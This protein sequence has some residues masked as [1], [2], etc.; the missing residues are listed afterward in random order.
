MPNMTA[1]T[2]TATITITGG[3]E[4]VTVVVEQ[5]G[6]AVSLSVTPENVFFEAAGGTETA[7]VSSNVS[8]TASDNATWLTLNPS[9]G[10]GNGN[11]TITCQ[12]YTGTQPRTAT[13]TVTG[14]GITRTITVEQAGIQPFLSANPTTVFF[15]ATGGMNEVIVNSNLNWTVSEG[16]TWLTLSP[17]TGNGIGSFVINCAPNPGTQIRNALITLSGGGLERIIEVGQA[18]AVPY[19]TVNQDFIYFNPPGGSGE[20]ELSSNIG[21]IVTSSETWASITPVSGNGNASLYVDCLVNNNPDPR[22]AVFT[23]IGGGINTSFTLEQLGTSIFCQDSETT[24]DTMLCAGQSITIGNNTYT[25]TGSYENLFQT[26]DGC[27]SL[28]TLDLEVFDIAQLLPSELTTCPGQPA[29]ILVPAGYEIGLMGV[30]SGNTLSLNVGTYEVTIADDLFACTATQTVTVVEEGLGVA[31]TGQATICANEPHPLQATPAATYLWS[32]NETTATINVSAPGTY[33]VTATDA[34]GCE[35]NSCFEVTEDLTFPSFSDCPEDQLVT[36]D[37]GETAAAIDWIPPFATDNCGNDP[38]V[39]QSSHEPGSI[40]NVGT[41]AVSYTVTDANGNAT[42]CTFSVTVQTTPTEDLTFYIDTTGFTRSGDT[43]CVPVRVLN[44]TEVAAFQFSLAAPDEMQSSL[45][46]IDAVAPLTNID[47]VGGLFYQEETPNLGQL[48]W[49]NPTGDGLTLADST[50]I[51]QIKMF[52][53]TPA[54]ECVPLALTGVP[55]AP[56]AF[57]IGEGAVIPDLLN[58]SICVNN[59]IDIIG[60]TYKIT[61]EPINLTEVSLISVDTT[62]MDTTDV[63]GRYD[64]NQVLAAIDYTILPARDFGDVEGLSVLDMIG[65]LRHIQGRTI[66]TNPY[67]LLAADV[68]LTGSITIADILEVRELIL[69]NVQA[70]PN[71]TS[72]FFVPVAYEFP[73]TLNPWLE[74]VPDR[75]ELI[76]PTD[77]QDID[78][79]G[80]KSGDINLSNNGQNLTTGTLSLA[81][82]EQ[83]FSAGVT[84]DVPVYAANLAAISGFQLGLNIDPGYL[85]IL[86]VLPGTTALDAGALTFGV[87]D[88]EEGE[89][90]IVFLREQ[91]QAGT[92]SDGPLFTLRLAARAAG[93]LSEVLQLDNRIL[94]QQAFDDDLQTYAI[95]LTT[96]ALTNTLELQQAVARLVQVQPNPFREQLQLDFYFPKSTDLKVELLDVQG[97]VHYFSAMQTNTGRNRVTIAPEQSLS[98]GI[99]FCRWQTADAS[100]V[101]K[102]VKE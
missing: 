39:V 1:Q 92:V 35:G 10:T 97:R 38:L 37:P 71:T 86:E 91:P 67:I 102:V 4:T 54:G 94:T 46:T 70:F 17:Q 12:P 95:E 21:W 23:I 66:I 9:S 3:G 60:E 11:F 20:I 100:G 13:I 7:L 64:F 34:S 85:Q 58:G 99:Y 41:T 93:R 98:N 32:T 76:A 42:T 15:A 52:V 96:T 8:W 31:I 62:Q 36:V 24:I 48:L 69:N 59:L 78:F 65:I 101:V 72:W 75:V 88:R 25:E 18:G 89:L 27:D 33:C 81:F 28:I 43:I 77:D 49:L 74:P 40:F 2:R 80:I 29:T 50:A 73:D 84:I 57:V 79:Y 68:N 19:L 45:I 56:E 6:E 83:A 30:P 63:A 53:D 87:H 26:P 51:F 61:N 47:G 16:A 14:G 44:F 22:E 5:L 55:L 90:P 82:A